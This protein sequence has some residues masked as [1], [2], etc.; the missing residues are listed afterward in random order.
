[1][2]VLLLM[3]QVLYPSENINIISNNTYDASNYTSKSINIPTGTTI[4]N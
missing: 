1:M 3:F 2:Q 4:D